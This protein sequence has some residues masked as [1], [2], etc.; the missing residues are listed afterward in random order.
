M[1]GMG[2]DGTEGVKSLLRHSRGPVIA[3]S[4]ESCVVFGMPKAVINNG[5]ANDVKH[6]DEIVIA[7]Y[8]VYEIKRGRDLNGDES[9]FRRL[10]RRK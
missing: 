2:S 5:L 10:Y 6:V 4:A 7:Y 8:D 3:E 1:T 9:I